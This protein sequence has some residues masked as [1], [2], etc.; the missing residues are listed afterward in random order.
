MK[1]KFNP[2]DIRFIISCLLIAGVSTFFALSYFR[3]AF[4]EA[5][6]DLKISKEVGKVQAKQF[7]A[8]RGW[9]I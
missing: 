9:D 7:I 3:Q 1:E 6:I 4:P 5:S 8:N 2:K